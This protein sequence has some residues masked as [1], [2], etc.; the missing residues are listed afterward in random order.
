MPVL[1]GETSHADQ[2]YDFEA[3][4]GN[5]QGEYE[6]V[7]VGRQVRETVC[8]LLP[9]NLSFNPHLTG[10][11][12]QVR[13]LEGVVPCA[14]RCNSSTATQVA[15]AFVALCCTTCSHARIVHVALDWESGDVASGLTEPLKPSFSKNGDGWVP[16]K[17]PENAYCQVNLMLHRKTLYRA[18]S[19]VWQPTPASNTD[20]WPESK[21][22][23]MVTGTKTSLSVV[24]APSWARKGDKVL[25][26]Y[27]DGR[28]YGGS[29]DYAFRS[30]LSAVQDQYVF[31]PGDYHF[32]SM[33]FWLDSSYDQ[34]SK[35]SGLLMQWKMSPGFPHGALRISNLGDYKLYFRGYD[36][37][38]SEN[39]NGAPIGYAKK[40]AW[41]DFKVF[42]RKSM[43]SDG[44]VNV[45]LNGKLV[46]EHTGRTLLKRTQKGYTK[47]GQ[48]TEIRD[49]RTVYYDAVEF[50]HTEQ[51][52]QACLTAMGHANLESW[53]QQGQDKPTVSI[54]SING[55][56]IVS[57]TSPPFVTL[58]K[59]QALSVAASAQDSEGAK[60]ASAGSVSKVEFFAGDC[61]L[62]S[63]T[64]GA[65][66][67]SS[68]YTLP[69]TNLLS[70]TDGTHLITAVVSDAD[71]NMVKSAPVLLHVGNQDQL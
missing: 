66:V 31:L 17:N 60:Y 8:A 42:Y 28:N 29:G 34:V 21:E 6:P 32:Y 62:G 10:I 25:R 23:T 52:Y 2:R 38:E 15:V 22:K 44:F 16:P 7:D 4:C 27:A 65:G 30:E 37:W 50:C 46:F 45:W 35:Y 57:V 13:P 39:G 58:P 53:I 61:S 64:T 1:L 54:T 33:S 55:V 36:L 41:N 48:Y 24:D 11:S 71:G 18:Y 70:A 68:T 63:V 12:R 26:V 47:F 67:G 9:S 3:S 59:G 56:S 49:E 51:E 43:G 5:R 40:A 19:L 69:D 14:R 20:C